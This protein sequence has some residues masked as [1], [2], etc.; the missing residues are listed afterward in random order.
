[1]KESGMSIN[2]TKCAADLWTT[3]SIN[4][5]ILITAIFKIQLNR[6]MQS[7]LGLKL[8]TVIRTIPKQDLSSRQDT[9][10]YFM[11]TVEHLR[12]VV[13]VYKGDDAYGI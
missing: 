6:P 11:R 2:S 8:S 10:Y 3:D 4:L 1:M 12:L 5:L 13:V 7:S 9:L